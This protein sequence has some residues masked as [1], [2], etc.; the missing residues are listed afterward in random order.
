MAVLMLWY[1]SGG[2]WGMPIRRILESAMKNL[3]LVALYFIPVVIGAKAIYAWMHPE[4]MQE[5][6]LH[7]LG[8][9]FLN[10]R[11]SFCVRCCISLCGDSCVFLFSR[12]STALEIRHRKFLGR[13]LAGI[14]GPAW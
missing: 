7:N 9:H 12:L 1:L 2:Q 14:S 11:S 10:C 4:N 8:E 6:M 3:W 5:G 13:V